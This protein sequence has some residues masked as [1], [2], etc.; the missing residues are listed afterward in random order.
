MS[1]DGQQKHHYKYICKGHGHHHENQDDNSCRSAVFSTVDI[2][3]EFSSRSNSRSNDSTHEIVKIGRKDGLTNGE[4]HKK[5]S[6]KDK[7]RKY[8]MVRKNI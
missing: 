6:K 2:Y 8:S 5:K 1:C 3:P 7:H 4:T